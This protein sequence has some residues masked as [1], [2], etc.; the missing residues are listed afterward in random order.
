MAPLIDQLL[1]LDNGVKISTHSFPQGRTVSIH[2]GLLVGDV[3]ATHKIAGHAAHLATY[4][5]SF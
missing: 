4:P 3:V 2:L 1:R 5:F